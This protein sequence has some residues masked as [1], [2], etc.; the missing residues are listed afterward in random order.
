[1]NA[2]KLIAI[3]AMAMLW[4]ASA[5]AQGW[6]NKVKDKAVNTVKDKVSNKVERVVGQAAD[7]VLDG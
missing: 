2:K 7:E 4:S 6:L 3:L 5:D 1:M